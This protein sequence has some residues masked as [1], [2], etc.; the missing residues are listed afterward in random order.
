MGSKCKL[1]L[2]NNT[3][4]HVLR[5]LV[6]FLCTLARALDPAVRVSKR[7]LWGLIGVQ[8][9]TESRVTAECGWK[10]STSAKRLCFTV[11]AF[12]VAWRLFNLILSFACSSDKQ[13]TCAMASSNSWDFKPATAQIRRTCYSAFKVALHFCILFLKG[14]WHI[15]HCFVEISEVI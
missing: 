8:T 11:A 12:D 2:T 7:L 1:T 6:D 14:L 10:Y 15:H 4:P 3:G 13:N 9:I 5:M